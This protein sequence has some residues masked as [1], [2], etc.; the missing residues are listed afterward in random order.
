M[1]LP[2]DEAFYRRFTLPEERK[3]TLALAWCG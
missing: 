1:R 3:D 2:T